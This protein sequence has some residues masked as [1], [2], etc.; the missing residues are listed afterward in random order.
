MQDKSVPHSPSSALTPAT[1]AVPG[2]PSDAP[3]AGAIPDVISASFVPRAHQIV[4][5]IANRCM[6]QLLPYEMT[7]DAFLTARKTR[8]WSSESPPH[9]S[10]LFNP[11]GAFFV[12]II[13]GQPVGLID[14]VKFF[15]QLLQYQSE[16]WFVICDSYGEARGTYKLHYVRRNV[17]ITPHL[18]VP[19]LKMPRRAK[20]F[21][22]N[23][24]NW[25]AE[26][27]PHFNSLVDPGHGSSFFATIIVGQ[28]VGVVHD[29][30]YFLGLLGSQSEL[31]YIINSSFTEGYGTYKT[32]FNSNSVRITPLL[33]IDLP[34]FLNPPA[35]PVCVSFA[36]VPPRHRHL[37][38][39][40]VVGPGEKKAREADKSDQDV[41]DPALRAPSPANAT[42]PSR[43]DSP[44]EI[45]SDESDT[46][47]QVEEEMIIT[48]PVEVVNKADDPRLAHLPRYPRSASEPP[49][50]LG[51]PLTLPACIHPDFSPFQDAGASISVA[52]ILAANP[53]K[54]SAR[55]AEGDVAKVRFAKDAEIVEYKDAK[56]RRREVVEKAF[57]KVNKTASSSAATALTSSVP[58]SSVPASSVASS[59]R[60][61][62]KSRDFTNDEL[63]ALRRELDSGEELV[64]LTPPP[65]TPPKK[66]RK[67][68][69][70][71]A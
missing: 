1:P 53:K 19:L 3:S 45:S 69:K 29:L 47:P 46:E 18:N 66:S 32:A 55:L 64:E 38:P 33:T 70:A 5:G 50:T 28:P 9:F 26:S 25:T 17:R 4:P 11:G 2:E 6:C 40:T 41:I 63:E 7:S 8:N 22:N 16:L 15:L 36:R 48:G 52:S 30:D 68:G 60:T 24:V 34:T 51:G 58:Q 62:Q 14:D 39:H 43:P 35:D 37:I 23:E 21:S 61:S 67:K 65:P 10:L 44:I 71:R 59:A 31:W 13:V 54:R 49:R 42:S 20:F 56:R 12:V 57:E 27:V